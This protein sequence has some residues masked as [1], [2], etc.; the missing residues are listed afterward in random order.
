[1]TTPQQEPTDPQ[2]DQRD[3]ER[4]S[5]QVRHQ[6]EQ[7][8][9]RVLDDDAPDSLADILTA[10]EQFER[11]VAKLG[12]DSFTNDPRSSDPDRREF[13]VPRRADDEDASSYLARVRTRTAQ[14]STMDAR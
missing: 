8:G 4:A 1:M 7:R 10:V 3:L 6:L 5:T 14:L 13:V 9:V 2:A 12:G 11:A